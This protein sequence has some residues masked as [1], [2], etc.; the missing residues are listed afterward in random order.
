MTPAI[1]FLLLLIPLVPASMII[2]SI[3]RNISAAAEDA[4]EII[5][6]RA[7]IRRNND[8]IYRWDRSP[9]TRP[10]YRKG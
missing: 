7:E 1:F 5:R 9:P 6:N 10:R 2:L 4:Q 3:R 8:E